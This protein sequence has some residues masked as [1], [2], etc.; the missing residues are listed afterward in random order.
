VQGNCTQCSPS[1]FA[2]LVFAIKETF[3]VIN[4]PVKKLTLSNLAANVFKHMQAWLAVLFD[5]IREDTY[6]LPPTGC[7]IK[8]DSSLNFVQY[9]VNA[10]IIIKQVQ[11]SF[12][13]PV[14]L[15]PDTIRKSQLIANKSVSYCVFV[16]LLINFI[17]IFR[18]ALER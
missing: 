11:P 6:V 4:V 10:V 18:I 7:K 15:E 2:L 8:P 5:K 16:V 13:S 9:P 17:K 3:R 12:K 1:Q 14:K